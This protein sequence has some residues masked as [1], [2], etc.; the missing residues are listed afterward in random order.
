MRNEKEKK[1]KHELHREMFFYTQTTKNELK[2]A[3]HT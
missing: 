1:T 2:I 3:I